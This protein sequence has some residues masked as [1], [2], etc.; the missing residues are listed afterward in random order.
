MCRCQLAV[1]C[2]SGGQIQRHPHGYSLWA[3]PGRIIQRW[4]LQ[5]PIPSALPSPWEWGPMGCTGLLDL[6]FHALRWQVVNLLLKVFS[7]VSAHRFLPRPRSRGSTKRSKTHPM[8][9]CTGVT[10][11]HN[12]MVARVVLLLCIAAAKGCWWMMEQPKG[13]LLEDHVAFQVFLRMLQKLNASVSRCSTSLCW[14]GADTRKPLWIYSSP[15]TKS[16][17]LILRAGATG[18]VISM[19]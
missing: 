8:G 6:G 13:S 14:F 3:G 1:I 2:M 17:V 5:R 12:V 18:V 10:Q 7:V 15:F 16:A 4:I 9:C 19:L 11:E